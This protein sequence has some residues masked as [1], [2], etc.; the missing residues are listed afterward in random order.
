MATDASKIVPLNRD[1]MEPQETEVPVGEKGELSFNV[2]SLL[3]VVIGGFEAEE[4][5]HISEIPLEKLINMYRTDG[6]VSG[7]YNL[8]KLPI[9]AADL[10]IK[11]ADGKSFKERDFVEQNLLSPAHSGGMTTSIRYIKADMALASVTGFRAYE[12]VWDKPK[13]DVARL[14]KLA[15]RNPLTI[16]ILQDNTGG[17]AGFH[18]RPLFSHR[19]MGEPIPIEI[20]RALLFTRNK[21]DNP[22]YGKSDFMAAYYHYDKMHKLYY[23]AHM[24]FQLEAMPSRIGTYPKNADKKDRDEFLQGLTRL[25]FDATLLKPEGW[26][27]DEFGTQHPGRS[28]VE[29]IEHHKGQMSTSVLAQFMDLG[30]GKGR[31][32]F[33]LSKDLSAIFL[34]AVEAY[35]AEIDDCFNSYV[36]PQLVDYNFDSRKYPKM[37]HEPL[38]KDKQ[39]AILNLF[40]KLASS[41]SNNASPHFLLEL[42]EECAEELELKMDYTKIKAQRIKEIETAREAEQQQAKGA[43]AALAETFKVDAEGNVSATEKTF[44]LLDQLQRERESVVMNAIHNLGV[45]MEDLV[46]D[47]VEEA[48]NEKQASTGASV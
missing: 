7:L 8:L 21:E 47:A 25:G 30:S 38:M 34:M 15:P 36:I 43:V 6:Q 14:H 20:P 22:L 19:T 13:I 26:V 27:V 48:F 32:S 35:T 16:N 33:A 10:H 29:L 23:I 1:I 5:M 18:Q 45:K 37:V 4:T 46:G 24:A 41:P 9:V 17:F 12:K 11:E 3:R 40:M 28:F 42:E 44:A 31:G 39:E 2:G